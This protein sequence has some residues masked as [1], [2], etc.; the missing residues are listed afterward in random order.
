VYAKLY[1]LYRR[2]HDAF[3]VGGPR[4]LYPVMK[5]LHRIREATR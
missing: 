4:D 2:I 3:G 5:E 1:G